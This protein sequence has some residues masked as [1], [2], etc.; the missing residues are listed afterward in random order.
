MSSADE[1]WLCLLLM[2]LF[3]TLL[4]L[5]LRFPN[6]SRGSETA[7]LVTATVLFFSIC[8]IFLSPHGPPVASHELIQTKGALLKK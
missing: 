3:G 5:R 1:A 8:N 2:A 6:A 4:Y 7:V